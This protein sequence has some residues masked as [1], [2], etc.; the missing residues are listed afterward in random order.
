[1]ASIIRI[2]RSNTAGNPTTLAAG[3]LAYSSFNGAGGGKL[4]V[5]MGAETAG[6]AANHFVIGGTYYT[7]LVDASVA[8]Y[9][10]TDASSIPILSSTGT[11]DKWYPGNLELISNT[12]TPTLSNADL[13][14]SGNG[15]GKV[16]ISN[17]WT[18]PS[19]TG[20]LN[21]VLTSNGAGGSS[22]TAPAATSFTL[23]DGTNT[24]TF[25]TGE[26]LTFSGTSPIS[27]SV[28]NNTITFSASNAT[29]S[30]KGIASFSS[31]NFSVTSGAVSL[32]TGGVSNSNLANSSI[33]INGS[34]ISLGGSISGLA[35]TSGDLSQFSS[36]SSSQL[37]SLI[38]DETGSGSL[39]F[40]I[41][42]TLTSPTLGAATATSITGS[43]GNFSLTAA[44][45]NNNI[46]LVPTGTGTVD[47][48]NKR[49]T[50]LY[51]PS[52]PQDA[53]T[54]NYVDTVAQGLH[55]HAPVAAATTAALSVSTSTATTLTL[56]SSLTTLDS[57]TLLDTDRILVK[58]QATQSQNGIYVWLSATPTIL[59]RATDADVAADLAGGDFVFVIHGSTFGDAGFVQTEKVTTL[60]SDAII[61]AQFSGAGLYTAGTGL[62]LT[63]TAFSVN[64][65]Q[66]QVTAL[67][68]ITTGTWN[69]DTIAS[70]KGGTGFTTYATGD[71][72]YASATNTLSK[73][74]A[75]TNGQILTLASGVPTWGDLDGGTY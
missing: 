55:V 30:A 66:T 52:N 43:S 40:A 5:G 38:S 63:G 68:I 16:K 74:T 42:P 75:G 65:S 34:A 45:G 32:A 70:N 51:D 26:T 57:Y 11:I 46:N 31:S 33:T 41:S 24:D 56:S 72:I 25:Y 60:G 64:A 6:N 12:I 59:T 18:L 44:S 19:T 13:V 53:A 10:T 8:G 22:W 39:V 50:N 58:N 21:Y 48:A 14:L 15:S 71:L 47:V 23:S 2:K 27:I 73:L 28:T 20:S 35:T 61:W 4:Y 17:S 7:G 54:K 62:T 67:G 3:E 36:T 1:M 29:T 49:I 9:L 69:A 37:A